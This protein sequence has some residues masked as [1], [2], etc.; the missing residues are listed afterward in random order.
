MMIEINARPG[1]EIQNANNKPM[2]EQLEYLNSS[3]SNG[4]VEHVI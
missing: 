3:E 4:A 1:I 2:R